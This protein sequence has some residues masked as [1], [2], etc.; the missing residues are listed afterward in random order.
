MKGVLKLTTPEKNTYKKPILIRINNVD[1]PNR[2]SFN[3]HPST[4]KFLVIEFEKEC[5]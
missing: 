3:G 2:F 1:S 4:S 5:W